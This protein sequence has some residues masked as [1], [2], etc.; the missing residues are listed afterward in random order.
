MNSP[1]IGVVDYGIGNYA[2]LIH[3]LRGLGLRIRLSNQIDDLDQANILVLPGV[4]SFPYAM[5]MLAQYGLSE[6]I[7]MRSMRG[8]SIIGICLGMQLFSESSEEVTLTKGLNIIPGKVKGILYDESH[9][10]WNQI[11]LANPDYKF[12]FSK[13]DWFY[14]NHTFFHNCNQNYVIANALTSDKIQIPAIINHQ[15]TWGIQFHPEKSQIDG[16]SFLSKLIL[17][18]SQ[19]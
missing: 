15:N 3:S 11:Q 7:K 18:L 5:N 10:G 17:H 2:S 6:Y 8:D 1:V 14:F 4:G 9:I 13:D 16:S 12:L 19:C